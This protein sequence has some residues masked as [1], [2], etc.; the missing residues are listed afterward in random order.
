MSSIWEK[1]PADPSALKK[2]LIVGVILAVVAFV[3]LLM[4]WHSFFVYVP[5]GQHLIIIAKNGEPLPPGEV[6]AEPGQKGIQ[7]R[8]E[9][10]GWHFVMPIIHA[11]E[12][13][14]NTDIPAGKLGLVTAKGG[15][16][17]PPGRV[18][19]EAGEQG[20]QREVLPPGSYR[21]NLRGYNVELVDATDIGPGFVGVRRRLLGRD[22]K[23]R[24]ADKADEKGIL[25]EVLQPGL[26]YLNPKEYEVLKTDVGI[27][28]TTFH[29]DQDPQRSTAITFTSKGG[30]PISMDCTVEWEILP[31]DMPSLV[32]EYGTR[33]AIERNVIDLQ[34]HAI[35]RDKGIDYGV[36]DYLEGNKR[37]AF[38]TDFTDGLRTVGKEKDVKVHSAFIRDIVI[39]EVYLKPIR[40][41]QIAAETEV[42]N[43][44]KEAT[45][46]SVAD[47]EREQQLIEQ[48]AKE[49]EAETKRL[50]ASIDREVENVGTRNQAEIEKLKAEYESQI[51]NLD[52]QRVQLLGETEAQVTKL[53]ETAKSSLY[54]MKMRVFNSD[55]E[56]FLRYS[57]AQQL[58]PK[59]MIRLYHSG[60]GTFWTNMEGRGVNLMISPPAAAA[61]NA[62][63]TPLKKS[64]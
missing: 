49:V 36:Q 4:T 61:P 14:Q 32:A 31:N 20:I 62:A 17:L 50:V 15:K 6:L 24:F 64:K 1:L 52:T 56:A 22:G 10:E 46:Q 38:Q 9:G 41:K 3:A 40:Q 16:L 63:P 28:Q 37:E 5:P 2:L 54:E 21:L 19:A 60:Q 53:K 55:A 26:Y 39:P 34:A 11:T 29:Y 43:K 30:F 51:A 13:E 35:G 23:S 47:M 25:R 48:R 12:I 27:V 42:T 45:A 7:K 33:N 44:A 18:L 58:N 59:M 8:V 57:F